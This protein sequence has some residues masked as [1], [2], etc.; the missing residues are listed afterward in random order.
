MTGQGG[1][2]MLLR[3]TKFKYS[4]ARETILDAIL[5][6]N[7]ASDSVLPSEKKLCEL[8]KISRI[9]LRAAL[10]ELEE[11]GIIIKRNGRPSRVNLDALRR[12]SVPLRR[13]AWVDV[14]RLGY[15]NQIYFD[16][17]RSVAETAATRNVKVDY[18]SLA[19]RAMA[20]NFFRRQREYDGLI[21]GEFTSRYRD[22][23]E[24]IDH[25]HCVCVDC[26]RTGIAHCVK[27]DCYRGGEIAARTMLDAGLRN[28]AFLGDF[29]PIASYP[30]FAERFRGF[31]DF[32]AKSGAP[33]PEDHILAITRPE[34][35]EHFTEF[36]KSRL[37]VLREIDGLF[38]GHDKLAVDLVCMLPGL[39]IT[40]P[41]KLAVIGFDGLMMSQFVSPTL[42]TIR[43]PVEE[44]G[45]KALEIVLN[46]SESASFP[47]VIQIPPTLQAGATV[48]AG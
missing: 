24:R 20:D 6:G 14:S 28:L 22:Y 7:L 27:T 32:M 33:L 16:I 38:V 39:G 5:A 2:R 4:K 31:A 45:R 9:T 1:C 46:P 8:L 21:L 23:L 25:P 11:A 19:S 42:T 43:Q 26:P 41:E 35:E 15:T 18:I 48:S 17:F 34:E 29:T 47:A 36:L 30:P 12:Q 40:I 37:P 44:I 10:H 3:D 13:I